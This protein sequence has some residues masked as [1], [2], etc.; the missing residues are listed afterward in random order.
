MVGDP[1]VISLK[2]LQNLPLAVCLQPPSFC[3]SPPLETCGHPGL[4][5]TQVLDSLSCKQMA[6]VSLTSL[7]L[8]QVMFWKGKNT[9]VVSVNC[10]GVV[11]QVQPP[12]GPTARR[13]QPN[14]HLR[15]IPDCGQWRG[16]SRDGRMPR[17]D[18]RARH[19]RCGS[20]GFFHRP[21]LC[22]WVFGCGDPSARVV[23]VQG[24]AQRLR[25]VSAELRARPLAAE[26]REGGSGCWGRGCSFSFEEMQ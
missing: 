25:G 5:L 13:G 23:G 12:R 14:P 22:G 3:M 19:S 9:E 8:W 11:R 21:G 16:G 1:I 10:Q 4:R 6:P 2:V 20:W 17:G 15:A 26:P 18:R 7:T 24:G